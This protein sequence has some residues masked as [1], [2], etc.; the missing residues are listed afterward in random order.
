MY[1]FYSWFAF[2]R[3]VVVGG[4]CVSACICAHTNIHSVA[5]TQEDDDIYTQIEFE[6]AELRKRGGTTPVTFD[7]FVAWKER[8]ARE[9][10][11]VWVCECACMCAMRVMEDVC[12]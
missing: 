4:V 2:V 12:G 5:L 9:R 8:K 11:Q 10:Q 6:R 1:C 3:V 7:S